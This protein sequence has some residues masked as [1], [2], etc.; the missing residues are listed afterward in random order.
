MTETAVGKEGTTVY[1]RINE[2]LV[3]RLGPLARLA[4]QDHPENPLIEPFVRDV[5]AD[6][7]V[8]GPDQTPD[9]LWH[10]ITCGSHGYLAQWTSSDGLHWER[11]VHHEWDGFSPF[12]HPHGGRYYLFYQ[13]NNFPERC[14]I[15]CRH[16]EDLRT[17]SEP[18]VILEPDLPWEDMEFRP[19]CRNACLTPLPDGTF[20]LYYSGGVKRIPDLG[21]E[22]PANIAVASADH[23]LGPYRKNPEPL[24]GPD[25]DDPYRNIGAGAM[26]VY[27]LPD[28]GLFVGFNNGMYWEEPTRH[29]RSAIHMLVSEDGLEWFDLPGNPVRYPEDGTWKGA[30][31]YQLCLVRRPGEWRMY[32]NARE[33]WEKGIERIGLATARP[34]DEQ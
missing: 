22:E 27:H 3:G 12:V 8:L 5:V 4:W 24:F 14:W 33:G 6:P 1:G 17:W 31:V 10:M 26:K 2:E 13:M 9:G 18:Q 7:T 30:L 19:T 32:Y 29:T 16:S 21:F 28:P 15:V 25:A 23:I 20:R 11:F 34:G